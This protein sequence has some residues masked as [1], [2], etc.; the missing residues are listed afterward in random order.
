MGEWC[1]DSDVYMN[2]DPNT[3]LGDTTEAH[4]CTATEK[5]SHL[6]QPKRIEREK[7]QQ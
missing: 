4:L 6:S 5:K 7:F 3:S 2:P 1:L